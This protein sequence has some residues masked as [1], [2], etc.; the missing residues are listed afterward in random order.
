MNKRFRL[1]EQIL[2]LYSYEIKCY[3]TTYLLLISSSVF[4]MVHTAEL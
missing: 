3:W 1:D 2:L 4:G